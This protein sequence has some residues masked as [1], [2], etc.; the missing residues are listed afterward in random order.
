MQKP[1]KTNGKLKSL[2]RDENFIH[3]IEYFERLVARV[4]SIALVIVIMV[5]LVDLVIYL[6]QKLQSEPVGFFNTT[7]IEIFG[8]FLNILIALELL[9][10]ITAYL[11]KQILQVQLVI[12]T[13]LIAVARKIIIFDLDKENSEQKLISLGIAILALSISY[14]LVHFVKE[15]DKTKDKEK[16]HDR[17]ELE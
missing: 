8:V 6:S 3:A 14:L 9:E 7:V 12:V 15:G 16:K 10:N 13:S 17:D 2:F 1:K 11:Q 4:L 5:A